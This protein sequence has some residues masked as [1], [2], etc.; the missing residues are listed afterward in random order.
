METI[1]S[2][3][4]TKYDIVFEPT[5]SHTHNYYLLRTTKQKTSQSREVKEESPSQAE[6]EKKDFW[7]KIYEYLVDEWVIQ[8]WLE[9]YEYKFMW[10]T[11][12]HRWEWRC[13]HCWFHN[14]I[15]KCKHNRLIH[16]LSSN[17]YL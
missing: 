11:G 16:F 10:D 13:K 5:L 3:Q 9:F 12:I 17:W 2:D 6:S 4:G 1:I 7:K 8:E 14:T 15:C